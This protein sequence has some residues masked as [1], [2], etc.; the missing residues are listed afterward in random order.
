MAIEVI[1]ISA[2]PHSLWTGL[3]AHC[4]T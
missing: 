1:K 3:N 2:L 4:Y